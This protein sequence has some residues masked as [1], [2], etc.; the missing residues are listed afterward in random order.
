MVIYSILVII[1]SFSF[2]Q[3]CTDGRYEQEVFDNVFE[4]F[5]NLRFFSFQQV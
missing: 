2:S 3:E 5:E 1:F 4:D